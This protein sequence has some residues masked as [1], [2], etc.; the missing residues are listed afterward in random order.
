M[1]GFRSYRLSFWHAPTSFF[2]YIAL[3]HTLVSL[4]DQNNMA[5]HTLRF[6]SAVKIA[7]GARAIIARDKARAQKLLAGI[8]PH[9]PNA[10]KS[11]E[12]RRRPAHHHHDHGHHGHNIGDAL[13]RSA[14]GGD[15][16]DVTDAGSLLFH[17]PPLLSLC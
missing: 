14:T 13:A 9:G 2:V 6:T 4:P 10:Y 11:A 7:E 3:H 15:T 12:L 17:P 8:Q 5:H 1:S 16:I